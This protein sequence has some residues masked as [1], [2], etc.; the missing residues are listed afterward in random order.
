MSQIGIIIGRE[1][2]ERVRKKSFIIM[3]VLMPVLMIALM[4]APALIMQ[5]SRGETKQIAVIDES[6]LILPQLESNVEIAF[7]PTQLT[8]EEARKTLPDHFGVLW[9]G[10]DILTNSGSIKLY[11]NSSSSISIENGICGQIEDILEA[12][13]LKSYNIANLSQILDEVKTTVTMQTF[14]NDESQEEDSQATSSIVSTFMG[15]ALGM[16]LYMFLIIYGAMV[17]QSVIEEKNSRV[18]EVMVSSV[19]PFD[20]MM[21]KILGIASIAVVQILVWGLLVGAMAA[22]VMPMLMPSDLM[23]SAQAMQAGI[24]DAAATAA[25]A[26]I[27]ADMLQAVSA[28]TDFGYIAM[29]FTYLLLFL[30]GGYLLYSAMFAAVGSSVDSIQDAQQLQ[31]PIMIPIILA[32]FVALSVMNDPN[33]QLAFWFSIFPLTS[34][35]VMIA[36]IPCGIPTWEIILSLVILYLS[37]VV[38]VWLAAKIYRVGIFMYGKKPSFK[39]LYKWVRYKY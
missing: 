33:S 4:A 17:M 9:I 22:F 11:A 19:K 21:G 25:A 7:E 20:L 26:G 29:I 30:I 39:E 16:L 13:K 36:R 38:M 18:L 15:F 12:T 24:P 1:F 35:I 31:T 27:D 5:F 10:S 2:N 6:G 37:F 28:L 23:A 14:R 34:P 3:T 32:F 8:I